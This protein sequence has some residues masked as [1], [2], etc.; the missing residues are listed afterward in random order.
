[1]FSRKDQK[2][3]GSAPISLS[4]TSKG[5]DLRSIID[6]GTTIKGDIETEGSIRIGGILIGN[7]KAKGKLVMGSQASVIGNIMAENADIEGKVEGNM[8]ITQRLELKPSARVI[9]DIKTTRLVIDEG[10]IFDGACHMG[11]KELEYE[12]PK[13]K[14]TSKGR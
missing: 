14:S 4:P 6:V 12:H 7:V 5:S 2:A 13:G 1:M 10:A 9:G 8:Q 3:G 11:N